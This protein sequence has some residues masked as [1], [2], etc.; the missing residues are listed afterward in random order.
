MQTAVV[1]LPD[2]RIEASLDDRFYFP[3]GPHIVRAAVQSEYAET[4]WIDLNA[5]LWREASDLLLHL[6]EDRYGRGTDE[7]TTTDD[8]QWGD[9]SSFLAQHVSPCHCVLLSRDFASFAL[10]DPSCRVMDHVGHWL[11]RNGTRWIIVG[12]ARCK[13]DLADTLIRGLPW[14]D[15]VF[16]HEMWSLPNERDLVP[17]MQFLE[18]GGAASPPEAHCYWRSNNGIVDL[19]PIPME[20]NLT[21]V[22]LYSIPISR[23]DVEAYR[24]TTSELL[25]RTLRLPEKWAKPWGEAEARCGS[26]PVK[27]TDGCPMQ[28][29]FCDSSLLPPQSVEPHE[30]V[31]YI[32]RLHKEAG[33]RSFFLL[34]RQLN[35]RPGYLKTFCR[36]LI[37]RQIEI[38]WSDS[39][40]LDQFD[41]GEASL[42]RDAGCI[43]ICAGI[44]TLSPRLRKYTRRPANLERVKSGL[45]A[46][47][48]SGIWLM[49]NF[50]VGLPFE[51]WQDVIATHEFLE[52]YREIYQW[53]L[54]SRFKLYANSL[55]AARSGD[56]SLELLDNHGVV[57]HDSPEFSAISMRFDQKA[58]RSWEDH[59]RHTEDAWEFLNSTTEP[60]AQRL[61]A[62]W[63]LVNAAYDLFGEK[64]EVQCFMHDVVDA[65]R[66]QG[67]EALIGIK[68]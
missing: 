20:A 2:V 29:A 51:T 3:L 9:L 66:E 42:L 55:F 25:P 68:R 23:S 26:I 47:H 57:I 62:N 52:E 67:T 53:V 30:L 54:L 63:P 48:E 6:A 22:R 24:H 40:N 17:F 18:C 5:L 61:S 49:I 10:N 21:P 43:R 39:I 27:L 37:K 46:L 58:G 33:V 65:I 1:V 14:V 13:K 59:L 38:S 60:I 35:F 34:N 45:V 64:R 7:E 44:E 32:E 15:A 50:I 31:D 12:G 19:H 8:T 56:F 11:R 28:C 16:Y 4:R 41:V 36:E